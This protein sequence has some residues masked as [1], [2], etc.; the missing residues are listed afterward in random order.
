MTLTQLAAS[1]RHEEEVLRCRIRQAYLPSKTHI[2]KLLTF[3]VSFFSSFK[4]CK[5]VFVIAF[6]PGDHS[7]FSHGN[8]KNVRLFRLWG[9]QRSAGQFCTEMV[10]SG[11]YPC[12]HFL[13]PVDHIQ[14]SPF[15][16]LKASGL[17]TGKYKLC[18]GV[19]GYFEYYFK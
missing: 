10:F 4:K 13:L 1:Y 2:I 9:K 16:R 15:Y 14:R 6:P 5:H 8:L 17:R 7:Q 12:R 18:A 11:Q 19:A 3:F